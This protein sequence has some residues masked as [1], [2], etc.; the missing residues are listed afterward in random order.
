MTEIEKRKIKKAIRLIQSD[1]AGD[2]EDG[3]DI[4]KAMVGYMTTAQ[5][6][7]GVKGVP[8][9]ELNLSV[10]STFNHPMMKKKKS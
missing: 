8:L 7:K 6:L 10:D 5:L 2:W 1:T 9:N 4:L 3:M